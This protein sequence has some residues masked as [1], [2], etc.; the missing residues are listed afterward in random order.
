MGEGLSSLGVTMRILIMT[1][2]SARNPMQSEIANP[3]VFR[4]TA[5]T[6]GMH[7]RG[8]LQLF[9]S[10][11]SQRKIMR[12]IRPKHWI[13]YMHVQGRIQKCLMGGGHNRKIQITH[14]LHVYNSYLS[15]QNNVIIY[16]RNT[17]VFV[18]NITFGLLYSVKQIFKTKYEQSYNG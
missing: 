1:L 12:A 15:F 10:R 11:F 3:L 6:I 14:I 5:R 2:W 17:H 16:N 8:R 9:I 13:Q 18:R 4:F 7:N